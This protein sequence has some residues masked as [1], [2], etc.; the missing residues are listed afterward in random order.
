[1]AKRLTQK[2]FNRKVCKRLQQAREDAELTQEAMA[3]LLGI[4]KSA[5]AKYENRS[6]IPLY[7]VPAVCDILG[8]DP[9]FLLTGTFQQE[10]PVNPLSRAQSSPSR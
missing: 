7:Y 6:P 10:R 8:M 4:D 3:K 1:M 9:W 2:E 5:Y